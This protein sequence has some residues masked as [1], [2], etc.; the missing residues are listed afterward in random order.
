ME[1]IDVAK[2][3]GIRVP[4]DLS[5]VGFD[6]NAFG[7]TS[8]VPLTTVSQPLVEMGRLGSENLSLI[9]RGKA[10]LPVKITLPTKLVKRDSCSEFNI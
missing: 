5:I 6:D 2:Q 10:K 1:L 8:S 4:Q 9:S 7:A 3:M